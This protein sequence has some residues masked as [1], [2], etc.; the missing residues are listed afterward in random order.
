MPDR[1]SLIHHEYLCRCGVCVLFA[2]ASTLLKWSSCDIIR[3][4]KT[5]YFPCFF[6]SLNSLDSK[7]LQKTKWLRILL[8]TA[9]NMLFIF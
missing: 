2:L 3:S 9:T 6:L 5:S 4:F 7:P 8:Y 1:V